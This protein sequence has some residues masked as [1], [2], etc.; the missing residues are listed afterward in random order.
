MIVTYFDRLQTIDRLIRKKGTGNP[1]Q[2]ARKL[3][4]SERH[5]YHALS[6]MKE[7]GAPI[8]YCRNRCTYYYQIHGGF[9][10]S[11]R[12]REELESS[13]IIDQTN[14]MT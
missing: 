12:T 4:I 8:E 1:K 9:D 14:S 5:L 6:Q 3:N 7:L 11:F 13:S 2:L 10:F